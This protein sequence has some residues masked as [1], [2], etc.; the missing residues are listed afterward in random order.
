M[1]D[2]QEVNGESFAPGTNNLD[3]SDNISLRQCSFELYIPRKV[4][5]EMETGKLL[6]IKDGIAHSGIKQSLLPKL[7]NVLQT[8]ACVVSINVVDKSIVVEVVTRGTEAEK[9]LLDYYVSGKFVRYYKE[10]LRKIYKNNLEQEFDLLKLTE[11]AVILTTNDDF[12]NIK[13]EVAKSLKTFCGLG[14]KEKIRFTDHSIFTDKPLKLCQTLHEKYNLNAVMTLTRCLEVKLTQKGS[15]LNKRTKDSGFLPSSVTLL[16]IKAEKIKCNCKGSFLG[17]GT[18]GNVWVGHHSLIGRVAIKCLVNTKQKTTNFDKVMLRKAKI[19]GLASHK[20]IL[21]LEGFIEEE[22]WLGI[23]M[24]HMPAGSLDHLLFNNDLEN[25]PFPLLLRMSYQVSDAVTYLHRFLKTHKVIHGNLKPQN[26]L[27]N[28][29]LNCRVADF[30]GS[31]LSLNDRDETVRADI[32][33]KNKD[34]SFLFTAPERLVSECRRLTTS[35]DVYS[36]GVVLYTMIVRKYPEIVNDVL[37]LDESLLEIAENK[38]QFQENLKSFQI[39][40]LLKSIMMKCLNYNSSQRPEMLEIRDKLHELLATIKASTMAVSLDCV[41][42]HVIIRADVLDKLCCKP[43][44]ELVLAFKENLISTEHLAKVNKPLLADGKESPNVLLKKCNASPSVAVDIQENLTA[45]K[46]TPK[47]KVSPSTEKNVRTSSETSTDSVFEESPPLFKTKLKKFVEFSKSVIK[48]KQP[49]KNTGLD[50]TSDFDYGMTLS[51]D[52]DDD[53]TYAKNTYGDLYIALYD[54][55]AHKERDLTF[56][57]GDRFKYLKGEPFGWFKVELIQAGCSGEE[58]YIPSNYVVKCYSKSVQKTFI[59]WRQPSMEFVD[60]QTGM[61]ED[62]EYQSLTRLW[63]IHHK[64]LEVGKLCWENNFSKMYQAKVSNS[65]DVT[66]KTFNT[67]RMNARDF[68]I[69]AKYM[70][71]LRHPNL[72]KFCGVCTLRSPSYIV[73]EWMCNGSLK[74]YLS[75]GEGRHLQTPVLL[76]VATQ[77]A[78]G[79]DYLARKNFV[80]IDLRAECVFV[81][82]NNIYKIADFSLMQVLEDGSY[83]A[84]DDQKLPIKWAAP[85]IFLDSIFTTKSDVWSFGI[86]LVEV[87]TKGGSPYP[88][89]INDKVAEKVREGYRM[90]Q[91]HNCPDQLYE[92]MTKCWHSVPQARPSFAQIQEWLSTLSANLKF[93]GTQPRKEK[94]GKPTKRRPF[95]TMISMSHNISN[96]WELD[97]NLLQIKSLFWK[98]EIFDIYRGTWRDSLEVA[99]KVFDTE[100]ANKGQFLASCQYIRQLQH[101]AFV[102][103][104]NIFSM[105]Q[106]FLMVTELLSNGSLK[107]Y[108]SSG[109][110]YHLQMPALLNIGAQVADGMTYLACKNLVHRDLAARNVFVGENMICKIADFSL[111]KVTKNGIYTDDNNTGMTVLAWKWAAP[112]TYVRCNFTTKSDI[113]SFGILLMEIITKGDCPYK[114]MDNEEAME[115]IQHG[116]RMPLPD[117]CPD[118]LYQMMIKCWDVLP[119]NRPSF[120]LLTEQLKSFSKVLDQETVV[121]SEKKSSETKSTTTNDIADEWEINR[122][123]LQITKILWKADL[124]ITCKGIIRDWSERR[125]VI[126]K[127][128]N[129][130]SIEKHDFLTQAQFMKEL[131]HDKIIKLHGYC[132]LKRPYYVVMEW[133][134]S[135]NLKDYLCFSNGYHLRTPVLINMGAQIAEGMAYLASKNFVHRD[136]AARNILVG[137]NESCKIS[138]FSLLKLTKNGLC[139]VDISRAVFAPKWTAPE[140]FSSGV[141]S[142]QSDVWSFGIVLM[143]IITKGKDPYPDMDNE[144]TKQAVKEGYRMPRTLDCPMHLYEIMTKCWDAIDHIRP[145][146]RQLHGW[147]TKF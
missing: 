49:K 131:Q 77:V 119:D 3:K 116:Y 45:N 144:T 79:M 101:P 117:H 25:I 39:F 20:H 15:S 68:M 59:I 2:L 133:M 31:V 85:E 127:C 64:F 112:E 138:D 130:D 35:M 89:M 53:F 72:V 17:S 73:T 8:M 44:G 111:M 36:F 121:K 96:E 93:V 147:L 51:G 60:N 69:Q 132:T 65:L 57:K 102:R 37:I 62:L 47:S 87:I 4:A 41:L 22:D 118:R 12:A 113:W 100:F 135:G 71:E 143:E 98:G 114:G 103:I 80:L 76:N 9:R 11:V 139:V 43:I 61:K 140:A 55:K 95:S 13:K 82:M 34:I 97:Q 24:E 88:D 54:Y 94:A 38:N 83:K 145:A 23:V 52:D 1:E 32:S 46:Q 78:K 126:L 6:E 7:C 29:D 107:D 92:I 16:K 14:D 91:P 134:S 28:A 108:L 40:A 56:R 67:D 137:E 42:K 21:R 74:D 86:L 84:T 142:T 10:Q 104:Y 18:I 66:M 81:G 105:E 110:G 50:K 141:F 106:P 19:L 146:F 99:V 70:N 109:G 26:I 120:T 30:G 123:L 136:L 27:L 48:K 75:N 58:G 63:E 33:S 124:F 125:K 5:D 129:A 122:K 90:Q 115:M 128:Y